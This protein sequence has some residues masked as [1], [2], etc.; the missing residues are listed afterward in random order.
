[1]NDQITKSRRGS[2]WRWTDIAMVVLVVVGLFI[3]VRLLGNVGFGTIWRQLRSTDPTWLILGLLA[4]QLMFLTQA[5][6]LRG[7]S[8]VRIPMLPAMAAPPLVPLSRAD[9]DRVTIRATVMP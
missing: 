6:V 8:A 1:M 7:A 2:H 4:A 5:V 3:L 9:P